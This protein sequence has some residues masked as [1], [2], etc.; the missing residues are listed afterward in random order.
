MNDEEVAKQ[1]GLE[2]PIVHISLNCSG[3][4]IG[5]QCGDI[6][7]TGSMFGGAKGNAL[8]LNEVGGR[9]LQRCEPCLSDLRRGEE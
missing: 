6:W 3:F 5:F 9:H 4:L 8:F 7:N 1:V 2:Y